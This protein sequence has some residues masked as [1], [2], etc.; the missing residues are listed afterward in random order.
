MGD[1][2]RTAARIQMSANKP[3]LALESLE[4]QIDSIECSVGEAHLSFATFEALQSVYMHFEGVPE[5]LLITSH[6]GC[7]VDGERAIYL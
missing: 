4:D 7:N 5:F 3:A 1:S 6:D 2:S